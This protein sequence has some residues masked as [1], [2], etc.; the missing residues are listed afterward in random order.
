MLR[1]YLELLSRDEF[2]ELVAHS[3]SDVVC[4]V[5][6]YDGCERWCLLSVD[7]DVE[8]NKVISAESNFSEGH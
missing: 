5:S 7:A 6:V 3:L 1:A 8:F 2:F 4:L